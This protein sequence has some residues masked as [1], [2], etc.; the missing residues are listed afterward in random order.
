[1]KYWFA[2]V[3]VTNFPDLSLDMITHACNLLEQ[4]TD[5]DIDNE[6]KWSAVYTLKDILNPPQEG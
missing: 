2:Q 6:T 1:M 5:P 4:L 3:I